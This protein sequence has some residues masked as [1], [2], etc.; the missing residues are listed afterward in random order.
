M[1]KYITTGRLCFDPDVIEGGC[2]VKL[3]IYTGKDKEALFLKC[4]IFGQAAVSVLEYKKKG[5]KIAV[6]GRLEMSKNNELII[7]SNNVEFV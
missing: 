7:V 3:A 5:E 6:D 1:N 4:F 2:K